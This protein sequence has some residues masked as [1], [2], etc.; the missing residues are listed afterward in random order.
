MLYN[1]SCK[2]CGCD[3]TALQMAD[4]A[5]PKPCYPPMMNRENWMMY[6]MIQNIDV[7]DTIDVSSMYTAN[8]LNKD[9]KTIVWENDGSHTYKENK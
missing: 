6:K 9:N 8:E 4:K 2:I 5:C 3:T 7:K 1:G